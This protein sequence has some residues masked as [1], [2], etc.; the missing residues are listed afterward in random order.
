MKNIEFFLFIRNHTKAENSNYAPNSR[1]IVR[2]KFAFPIA[3]IT[4]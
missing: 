3:L 4:L 2:R 1:E